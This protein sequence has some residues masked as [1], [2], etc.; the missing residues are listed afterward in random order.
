MGMK[1]A[2]TWSQICRDKALA[3]LPFKVELT[4]RGIIEMSPARPRH[5]KLQLRIGGLM[6]QMLPGGVVIT[7]CPIEGA[8]QVRVPD[9][10]WIA[11]GRERYNAD[12][13]ALVAAP[14]ICVEVLS[15]NNTDEEMAA[16]RSFYGAL[17]CKEFWTC[18]ESGE[19][20]FFLPDGTALSASRISPDFPAQIIV[21]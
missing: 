17:G 16:K 9:V 11:E 5:G 3:E 1:G 8:D 12:E 20:R 7:E 21:R 13:T 2:L 19:M 14:D 15:P 10:C 18:A 6:E 4:P